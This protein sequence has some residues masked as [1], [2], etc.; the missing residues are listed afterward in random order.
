[1]NFEKEIIELIIHFIVN[2]Y[3]LKRKRIK[4]I[5]IRKFINKQ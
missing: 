4:N 1:M 2:L 3:N 5:I